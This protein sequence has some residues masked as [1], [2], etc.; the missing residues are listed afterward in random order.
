[1]RGQILFV[2]SGTNEGVQKNLAQTV[3]IK[4]EMAP[5]IRLISPKNDLLLK[6]QYGGSLEDLNLLEVAD[7]VDS[8]KDGKIRP[9]FKS[10]DVPADTSGPLTT[11]V[12][13][14][15]LSIAE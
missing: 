10:E 8:F 1:M 13:R 3:G 14:N 9:Y 2:I 6:Y 5:A 15:F 7:F 12:G 4:P 11:M